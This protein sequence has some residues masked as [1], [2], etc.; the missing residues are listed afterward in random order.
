M[1]R[2]RPY[3][4]PVNSRKHVVDNQGGLVADTN[5]VIDIA[6]TVDS[7]ALA[8]V[9]NVATA[10]TI[11]SIFLN[12]QVAATATAAL[13]NVYMYIFKNPGNAISIGAFPKGNVVGSSDLKKLIFHQEMI[14]T[15]KNTTAIPRTMFKGVLK[16]PK[17]MQR[18][19]Y[20]DHLAVMLY[21]PGITFDYCVQCIYKEYR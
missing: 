19:G 13:A 8:D 6:E 15:E 17:H 20:D 12:I 4:R 5:T 3:L 16:L 10:S 18:F 14:M 21:S 2:M 1:P 9:D 11:R 7:P